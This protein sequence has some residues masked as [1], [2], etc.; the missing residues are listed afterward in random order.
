MWRCAIAQRRRSSSSAIGL[1]FCRPAF[2]A[3]CPSDVLM[4]IEPCTLRGPCSGESVIAPHP[5]LGPSIASSEPRNLWSIGTCNRLDA[6]RLSTHPGSRGKPQVRDFLFRSCVNGTLIVTRIVI[7]GGA[8]GSKALRFESHLRRRHAL[9]VAACAE[10]VVSCAAQRVATSWG[11]S[12]RAAMVATS[13]PAASPVP[14]AGPASKPGV[15][16][17]RGKVLKRPSTGLELSSMLDHFKRLNFSSSLP[18]R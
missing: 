7:P 2:S 8:Q 3:S 11:S 6:I 9:P 4:L 16:G 18:A 5:G 1:V 13:S 17:V 10:G 14:R 15:G 12:H